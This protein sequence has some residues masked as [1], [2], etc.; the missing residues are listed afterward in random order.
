MTASPTNSRS[1]I[2]PSKPSDALSVYLI[3]RNSTTPEPGQARVWVRISDEGCLIA[4]VACFPSAC[5]PG[6]RL[7][8]LFICCTLRLPRAPTLAAQNSLKFIHTPLS[9]R[10]GIIG[11]IPGDRT[12]Q[13]LR[14]TVTSAHGVYSTGG[15][16][17]VCAP[18]TLLCRA[19]TRPNA[20]KPRLVWHTHYYTVPDDRHAATRVGVTRT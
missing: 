4:P 16:Q 12:S 14:C 1:A 3:T 18:S 19:Y 15:L 13:L 9:T 11:G 17:F 10:S 5:R 20:L 8:A 2:Q 7:V 6:S